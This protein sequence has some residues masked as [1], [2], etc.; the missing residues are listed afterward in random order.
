MCSFLAIADDLFPGYDSH[1]YK[2]DGFV[3]EILSYGDITRSQFKHMIDENFTYVEEY[4]KSIDE[5]PRRKHAFTPYTELM[6]V[7]YQTQN[8]KYHR[9][10]YNPKEKN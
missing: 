3:S 10:L 8:D 1:A 4:K 5:I 2:V 7:L 9:A 6:H